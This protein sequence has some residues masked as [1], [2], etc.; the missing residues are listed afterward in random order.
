MMTRR[1]IFAVVFLSSFSSLAYEINLTRI[2]SISFSYHFAFMIISIAMLGIGASGTFLSLSPVLRAPSRLALESLLLGISIPASY[3]LSKAIPFDPLSLLWAQEQILNIGIYYLTLS[4]PFFFTGLIVAK[5]FLAFSDRAGLLYGGD[6]LGAGA[7]SV[8]ILFLLVLTGPDQAVLVISSIALL[9]P[10]LL[11]E[12]KLKALALLFLLLT[13]SGL[14]LRPSW[15][16]PRISPYKELQVALKYPGAEHLKTFYSPF[17]RIDLFKSPAVRF[18]PGMSLTYFNP[19]PEQ[20]GVS[21]D[22]GQVN[23]VTNPEDQVSLAFLRFLPSSLPYEIRSLDDVL[24]IDPKGGLPVLLANLAGARRVY[25]VESNPLMI[26]IVQNDL[27]K[28][29]G[30]LYSENIRSGLGRSFLISEEKKFDLIDFSLMGAVPSGLFGI[31]ED[32]RYTVEA[33]REYL[34]HLK[35][36]GFLSFT[37]YL[38]P[39]ARTELRLLNTITAAMEKLGAKD[40]EKRMVAIRSWGT[41]TLLAKGSPITLPEIEAV[42]SFSMGR[43]FDLVYYPGIRDEETNRYVRM[44]SDVYAS[45]F[46]AL[47]NPGTRNHFVDRYLFDIRPVRDENPFFHSYLKL[48]NLKEIYRVMGGKWQYFIEEG[49]L[50]PAVLIQ[51]LFLSL[52]LVLLPAVAGKKSGLP[53]EGSN[54]TRLSFFAFLG[55]GFMFVE[56]CLVQKMILPLENPSYAVAAVLASILVSSGAGS[57]LSYRRRLLGTPSVAILISIIVIFYSLLLPFLS[58]MISPLPIP[59]K[60]ALVFLILFPLGFFMGVPFPAGIRILGERD[61]SLIPW[62]WAVNGCFSVLSPLLT[63]MLAMV[64]GFRFVLWLGAAAYLLAFLTSFSLP[65]RPSGQRRQAPSVRP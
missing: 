23:A 5:A 56:V 53:R 21:V 16:Q 25:K 54:I 27:R 12:K 20:L 7:G 60:I 63:I 44:P 43:R 57:L 11:G 48:K 64:L 2:F 10:L 17:S 14:I 45:A 59:S 31:S 30:G 36:N 47:L 18:A 32:Y 33:F 39:P 29:S 37:L 61:A 34:T 13:L 49:Y 15:M 19:L 46:K 8:G 9:S 38:I 35:P 62:A 24:L 26:E 22:G 58:R 51:V 55:L 40:V 41:L 50:L 65:R 4:L 52:V 6:L 28:F 1:K 42:K 3:L